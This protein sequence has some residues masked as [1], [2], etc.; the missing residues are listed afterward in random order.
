MGN[1][2]II[3]ESKAGLF[4]DSQM[5]IADQEIFRNRTKALEK[6]INQGWS[7]SVAFRSD[8]APADLKTSTEDYLFV[9]T[10]KPLNVGSGADL[11][12]IYPE[13]QLEYPSAEA[14]S[15]LPLERVYFI[16]VDEFERLMASISDAALLHEFLRECVRLDADPRTGKFFFDDHLRTFA[17]LKESKFLTKALEDSYSRVARILEGKME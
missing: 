6:A 5:A 14:K 2:N 3:V 12:A 16:S 15:L 8:R 17:G 1:F 9:V 7:A 13:G 10:N 4:D 11:R